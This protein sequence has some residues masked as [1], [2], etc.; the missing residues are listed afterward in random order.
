MGHNYTRPGARELQ[1]LHAIR[2]HTDYTLYITYTYMQQPDEE[3]PADGAL[4]QVPY[5]LL[6][7]AE[8]HTPG[9]TSAAMASFAQLSAWCSYCLV[10]LKVRSR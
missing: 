9:S 2:E 3:A 6:G 1:V 5:H 7:F 4:K 10:S 8:H